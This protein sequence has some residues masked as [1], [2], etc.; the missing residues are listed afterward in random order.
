M[1]E[2]KGG[3]GDKVSKQRAGARER[4]ERKGGEG[5]KLSRQTTGA[6]GADNVDLLP[7]LA[8]LGAGLLRLVAG[9]SRLWPS[10]CRCDPPIR[11][12]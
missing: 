11:P 5:I 10:V 1:G 4:G 8:G 6:R 7:L 3:E 2:R 12:V 9:L